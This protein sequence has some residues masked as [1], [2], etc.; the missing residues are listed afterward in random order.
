M[1]GNEERDTIRDTQPI[2]RH[3]LKFG[4]TRERRTDLTSARYYERETRIKEK[5]LLSILTIIVIGVMLY[6]LLLVPIEHDYTGTEM[7][8]IGDFDKITLAYKLGNTMTPFATIDGINKSCMVF[9][10]YFDFYGN[11]YEF[12]VT[13]Y[14]NETAQPS[15]RFVLTTVNTEIVSCKNNITVTFNFDATA[16]VIQP[17]YKNS[18]IFGLAVMVFCDMIFF[19]LRYL[20]Q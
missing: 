15:E 14:Y 1:S 9:P 6:G 19:E 18:W 2:R 13:V 8:T 16:N 3:D 7:T 4:P 17:L 12:Y 5:K 11:T 10:Q 20:I